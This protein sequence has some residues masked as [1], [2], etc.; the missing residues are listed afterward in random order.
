MRCPSCANTSLIEIRMEVGGAPVTFRRCG[1]CE[2]Q[3]WESLDVPIS[4]DHV[5]NLARS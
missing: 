5:L 3:G 4:L 1:R 2:T